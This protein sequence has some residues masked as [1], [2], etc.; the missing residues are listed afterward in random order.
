[1]TVLSDYLKQIR[2]LI[3][4]QNFSKVNEFDIIAWLNEGRTQVAAESG[5][6]RF[7]PQDLNTVVGQEIYPFSSINLVPFPGVSAVMAV[8]TIAMIWGNFQYTVTRY[9]FSKY[10]ARIRT[11]TTGYQYIPAACAQLGQGVDGTMYLYPIANDIYQMLWDCTGLPINLASDS[12][13]EAI[14]P[15]W[16][17]A[18]QFYAAWQIGNSLVAQANNAEDALT[19]AKLA[20]RAF[21]QYTTFMKRARTFAQPIFTSNW[22]G[23]A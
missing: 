12:D 6:I 3:G 20:D 1:M 13:V 8:G 17:T 11:Y 18:V 15:I 4:E 2:R 21:S 19:V 14:P 23:R 22:Y 16:T 9:S 10:Q 5:C 7:V